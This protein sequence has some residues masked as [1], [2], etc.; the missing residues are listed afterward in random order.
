LLPN[1]CWL[2]PCGVCDT[3]FRTEFSIVLNARTSKHE[4][5]RKYLGSCEWLDSTRALAEIHFPGAYELIN[6]LYGQMNIFWENPS[7]ASALLE[8]NGSSERRQDFQVKTIQA[9]LKIDEPALRAKRKLNA[10]AR[11]S[12][13]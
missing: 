5:D 1:F 2:A 12:T 8:S 7:E 10:I 3:Y 6:E 4:Y 11:Y 13:K 9:S